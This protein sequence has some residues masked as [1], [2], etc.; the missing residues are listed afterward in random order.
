KNKNRGERF[1]NVRSLFRPFD[2]FDPRREGI[3]VTMDGER[4]DFAQP[5]VIRLSSLFRLGTEKENLSVD[6]ASN[7][8]SEAERP[9]SR[10]RGESPRDGDAVRGGGSLAFR[11]RCAIV[12]FR[13]V[14]RER[15][16]AGERRCTGTGELKLG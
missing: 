9:T 15:R 10:G 1:R 3:G 5:S 13:V 4:A 16:T 2:D 8:V 12:P 14:D 6:D 7:R 11:R